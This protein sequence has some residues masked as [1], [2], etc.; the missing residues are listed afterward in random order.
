MYFSLVDLLRFAAALAVMCFHYFTG[1]FQGGTG[2]LAL[3]VNYGFLGV[4]LFFIISGF[5]IYFSIKKPLKEYA[6]SRFLRLYPLFWAICTFTYVLTRIFPGGQPVPFTDY[7]KNLFIVNNG[8][9]SKMV[10]GSYWTLTVEILFYFYIGVF[11]YFFSLKKIEWFYAGWLLL[12][13]LSFYLGTYNW[14]VFKI[15]LVRYAPYFVFGGALG[16]TIE[17]WAETGNNARVRYLAVMFLS[18]L[19]PIYISHVLGLITG[20]ITNN[21]GIYDNRSVIIAESF[22]IIMPLAAYF[23]RYLTKKRLVA[24]AKVA[25]GITYPLYLLHQ[26]IGYMII[27][28]YGVYGRITFWSLVIAG[29]M[30]AV[31]YIV[32]IYDLKIRKRLYSII[33][34]K[35]QNKKPGI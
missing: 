28:L 5:V 23:S 2:P 6:L 30:V 12:S 32:Y 14:L 27:G 29:A 8:D 17:K 15:L 13:F 26:K 4:Q 35:W 25:G 7:L 11:V 31:G 34:S 1:S 22:F 16:L 24:A 3:F 18:A 33:V 21:F 9:V 10:D 19:L 20:P